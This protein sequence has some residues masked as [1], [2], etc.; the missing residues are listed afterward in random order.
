MLTPT[1][2]RSSSIEILGQ[3]TP[4]PSAPEPEPEE[5]EFAEYVRRAEEQRARDQALLQSGL[6]GETVRESADIQI[7]STIPGA[8]PLRV[9]MRFD[10]ALRLVRE[11]WIAIQKKKG[12]SLTPDEWDDIVLTWRSKKVYN[13]TTLLGL[14]IR[15][16]GDRLVADGPGRDGFIESQTM[17][18]MEAWTLELFQQMELDEELQRRRDAGEISDE[19]VIEEPVEEIKLKVILKSRELEDLKLMVRPETTV[20]TLITG[21]R[22]QRNL[23]SD[24]D[25]S[26]WFDGEKLEEHVTMDEA[27]IDDMDTIE[28]HVK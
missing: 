9:K 11:T 15:P 21:F 20:E 19:E 7:N 23:G 10:K 14:G 4:Q 5:D 12:L 16:Q 22:T 1:N 24:R 8:G 3:T 18:H 13:F 27:E 26:L 28:V 25:V 6:D 2:H 17:V